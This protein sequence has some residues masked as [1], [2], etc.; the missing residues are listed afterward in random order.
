MLDRI[1]DSANCG[2]LWLKDARVA[3]CV[4][5][6]LRFC[7]TEPRLYDLH[8]YVVMAN[9]VHALISPH[10]PLSKITR[11]VKGF[12]ARK[13]NDILGRRGQPF[14]QDESFDHWVRDEASFLRIRLYIEMNPVRAG[15]IQ[16][17]EDWP[18]SSAAR[19]SPG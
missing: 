3:G 5:D 14:W 4:A 2:S 11:T 18:W 7:E 8:A 13:A 9:H 16:K 12:S 1:L 15:L 10:A 17:P 19:P 6:T